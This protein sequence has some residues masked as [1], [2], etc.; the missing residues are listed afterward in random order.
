LSARVFAMFC[1]DALAD[2]PP[3]ATV[4]RDAKNN[5]HTHVDADTRIDADLAPD[6]HADADANVHAD[7]R[8]RQRYG[9]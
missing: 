3:M 7:I 8:R 2:K 4:Q 9:R 6:F 5:G 1:F